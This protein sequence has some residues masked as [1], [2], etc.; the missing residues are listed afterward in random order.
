MS[1]VPRGHGWAVQG[2][3]S[4]AEQ[5]EPGWPITVAPGRF[6][7]TEFGQKHPLLQLVLCKDL[8]CCSHEWQGSWEEPAELEETLGCLDE[9]A[10]V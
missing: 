3:R 1:P 5:G 6:T 7:G 4:S 9:D 2:T 8:F 10:Q